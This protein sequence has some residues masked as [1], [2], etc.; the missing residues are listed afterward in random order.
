MPLSPS[1]PLRELGRALNQEWKYDAADKFLN[2]AG[3]R[4]S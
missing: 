1:I 2:S 3:A 4:L